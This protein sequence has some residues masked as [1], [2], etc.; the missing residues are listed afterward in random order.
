MK[1]K[2]KNPR[3]HINDNVKPNQFC[4]YCSVDNS[5]KRVKLES[6]PNEDLDKKKASV[7]NTIRSLGKEVFKT[8]FGK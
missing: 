1:Y 6:S 8:F 2:C 7:T 5:T 4:S 3:C